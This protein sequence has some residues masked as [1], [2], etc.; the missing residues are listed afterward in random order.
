M[1]VCEDALLHG[2]ALLVVVATGDA[3]DLASKL[4]PEDGAI[5]ILGRVALVVEVVQVFLV[6]DLNDFLEARAGAGGVDL[7][8]FVLVLGG[9]RRRE[10]GRLQEGEGDREREIER[11]QFDVI[12]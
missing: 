12:N 9:E 3:Q 7:F 5:N 10:G 4:L 8:G 6:F 2:V 11:G 1:V